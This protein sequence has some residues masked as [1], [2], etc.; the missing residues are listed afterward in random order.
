VLDN[1][2]KESKKGL[3]DSFQTRYDRNYIEELS[4]ERIF[5]KVMDISIDKII[6]DPDQ[7]RKTFEEDSLN[8]LASSIKEKGVLEPILVRKSGD[9]FVIIAGERRWRASK[10]AEK[11]S[12]PAIILEP[13]D[14]REIKEIQIIENLQREDI[15]VIERARVIYDYLEPYA[16]DKNIKTLLINMRMGRDVPESFAH[17]VS[18]LCKTIGKTPATIIR[19]LSLLELPQ[20]I[21]KKVDSPDSPLTSKHIESLLKLKDITLMKGV[22]E[23]IEKE[24]LSSSDTGKLV[25]HIAKKKANDPLKSAIKNIEA[26][27]KRITFVEKVSEL[28]KINEELLIIRD[29]VEELLEKLPKDY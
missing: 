6:P 18:A 5:S 17:T 10:I 3:P 28:E 23:L 22:I 4:L 16:N 15:S 20:D 27:A 2:P 12:I 21:Q 1:N 7:P 29:L 19:W 13:K 11:T 24:N 14:F 26:I 25:N 8:E 9:H